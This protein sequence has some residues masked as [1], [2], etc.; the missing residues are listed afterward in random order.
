MI[1]QRSDERYPEVSYKARIRQKRRILKST[2]HK[3]QGS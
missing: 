3:N 1:Y 2:N